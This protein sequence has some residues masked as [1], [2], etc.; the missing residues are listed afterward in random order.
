MNA[1]GENLLISSV[2]ADFSQSQHDV[3]LIVHVKHQT[4]MGDTHSQQLLL[5]IVGAH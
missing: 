2:G 5:Q 1:L 3:H 4:E